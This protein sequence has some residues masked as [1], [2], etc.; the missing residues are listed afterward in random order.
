[1]VVSEWI[2][3]FLFAV[4]TFYLLFIA[5]KLVHEIRFRRK[6]FIAMPEL[7]WQ[8]QSP[9]PEAEIL[10]EIF[11]AGD[12][13]NVAPDGN[14]PVLKALRAELQKSTQKS[15]L[16]F[17]GDNVYPV[18]LPPEGS[19]RRAAAEKKLQQQINLVTETNCRAIF[20]S[21]NHDWN[22]GRENGLEQ[23]LRQEKFVTDRL[24]PV[25]LPSCGC[26]G[27]ELIEVNEQLAIL[28][29]NT[30]WWVQRGNRPIG[31]AM[32][33]KAETEKEVFANLIRILDE[34]SHR[35]ILIAAH[36][37]LYSNA[38]HGGK[39]TI[40]HHVFPLT[41]AHKKL[42]V[43]LPM[44]GSLYPIY[45]RLFGAYEDMSHPRYKRMRKKLLRILQSHK[46]IVYAAGHDHNLQHFRHK[47]N[48]FLISGSA[49]KTAYVRKGGKASFTHEHL[50]FM[51]L[52]YYANG[53]AWLTVLEPDL[54]KEKGETNVVYKSKLM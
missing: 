30:Q 47:G 7:L 41:A 11:L 38:L 48:H 13:G 34:N 24:G 4:I 33:C 8:H 10:Q 44:A 53:E 36:H 32:G 51:K 37:P 18:G 40:K 3:Y 29:L 17:L 21:G 52:C 1:M 39:H 20:L 31:K 9:G 16:I 6:I 43:P 19:T 28:V 50:G 49:S 2:W 12:F 27:P 54:T 25:F 23:L 26:P 5:Y 22:K 46:N 35:R 14:D 15:T 42:Y 45:R